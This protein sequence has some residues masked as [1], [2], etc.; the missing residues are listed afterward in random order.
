M[1]TESTSRLAFFNPRILIGFAL[2]TA[3]LV[4][5]LAPMNSAAA[6]DNAAEERSQSVPVQAPGRWRATGDLGT[7]REYHT[8]T[9]L[10]DGDVLVAGGFGD[11]ANLASAE[12]YNPAT[13]IWTATDS[14]ANARLEHTATLLPNG[15]VLVAGGAGT[16]GAS[17]ELYNPATGIWTATGSMATARLLHT[18][19]LL[20]NGEV[21]VAGGGNGGGDSQALNY[22]IRRPGRRRPPAALPLHA[23]RTRRPYCRTGKCW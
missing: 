7:A 20:P 2:Y 1:K 13:G 14:L 15:K 5:A 22:T 9:L 12:L 3:G 21:L 18:A 19:T 10:P 17:A 8:A 4:L 6:G 11:L 16:A 23:P